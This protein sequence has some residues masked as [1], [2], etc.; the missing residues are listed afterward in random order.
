MAGFH[1]DKDTNK[2]RCDDCN[3]EVDIK[4]I[5]TPYNYFGDNKEHK[6]L[7]YKGLRKFRR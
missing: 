1:K 4:L 2:W 7:N 3:E 5:L 6:C